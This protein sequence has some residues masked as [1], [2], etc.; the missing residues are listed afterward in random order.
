MY[1]V[2]GDWHFVDET[3]GAQNIPDAFLIDFLSGLRPIIK[4]T[5]PETIK[6]V[7]NGDIFDL[8]ASLLWNYE[9]KDGK[10]NYSR[11]LIRPWDS[12]QE[13]V[14]SRAQTI[15]RR[16]LATQSFKAFSENF[17]EF[18]QEIAIPVEI[19]YIPRN[20]DCLIEN[21]PQL[22]KMI[23]SAFG[24]V[25]NKTFFFRDVVFDQDIG[26][27]ISHGNEYDFYINPEEKGKVTLG[28][29]FIIEFFNRLPIEIFLRTRDEELF[30][31]S[32]QILE[33]R[34]QRAALDFLRRS[35]RKAGKAKIEESILGKLILDLLDNCLQ[36]E[37]AK[38]WLKKHQLEINMRPRALFFYRIF[39]PFLKIFRPLRKCL[40]IDKFF[41]K[42][43]EI[44]QLQLATR[45][46]LNSIQKERVI[47]LFKDKKIKYFVFGHTHDFENSLLEKDCIYINLG[48]WVLQYHKANSDFRAVR[49][50]S[51]GLF[52]E[53]GEKVDREFEIK[54]AII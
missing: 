52:F 38:N 42:I 9:L 12:N 8:I 20:H 50:M 24:L 4:N 11:E 16:I 1:V 28:D 21:F 7:F 3:T 46:N 44:F 35:A 40:G 19:F 39:A 27:Y 30:R 6:F 25:E 31:K 37:F 49:N 36:S 34:P 26:L 43:Y 10:Y 41:P 45:E 17:Q 15:L 13:K 22:R 33:V 14:L 5:R 54:Q 47:D 51:Y 32:A 2:L 29:L 53:K 23:A 48:S 18:C